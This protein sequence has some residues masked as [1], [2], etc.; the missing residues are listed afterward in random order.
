MKTKSFSVDVGGKTM[1]A[2]FLTGRIYT[3]HARPDDARDTA[4]RYEGG[5]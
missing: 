2:E 3:K 5:M 4:A 1:A